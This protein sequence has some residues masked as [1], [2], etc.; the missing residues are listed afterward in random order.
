MEKN[1]NKM[2]YGR[3]IINGQWWRWVKKEEVLKDGKG[4]T[5]KEEQGEERKRKKERKIEN[6]EKEEKSKN[7]KASG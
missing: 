3:I 4:I 5:R 1:E 2:E 6:G 7:E